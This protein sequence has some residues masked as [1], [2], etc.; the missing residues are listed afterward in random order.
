VIEKELI[1]KIQKLK[2]IEPR[3]DWVLLTKSQILG[4][5]KIELTPFFIVLIL[6]MIGF[7]LNWARVSLPGD[8]LYPVKKA[9]ENS[10]IP[11]SSEE[12][13]PKLHLELA[14][15]RLED[16]NKITQENRV[17]N[18]AP[19]ISEFQANIS[20]AAKNLAKVST[21]TSSDSVLL[22][23]IVSET[24]KLEENKEKI[25]ARGVVVGETKEWDD[26]LG[27]L[28][29]RELEALRVQSLTE[30]QEDILE[31]AQMDFE[32]G[33]YSQALEKILLFSYPQE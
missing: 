22:R 4:K 20:E 21:A 26:A 11:F 18:L 19:A 31:K 27:L 23:E 25:E 32:A 9:V 16:L 12:K 24:Q 6:V 7:S 13:R 2:E 5:E 10:Q 29:E 33:N 17:R 3:K 30:D 8:F 14:N 28:V 1:K 15:K